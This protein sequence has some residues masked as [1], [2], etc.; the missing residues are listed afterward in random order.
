MS[1]FKPLTV[2]LIAKTTIT[3]PTDPVKLRSNYNVTTVADAIQVDIEQ[4]DMIFMDAFQD[5]AV[6]ISFE[7][8]S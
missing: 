6:D 2:E 4:A 7:V 1:E 8:L 3:I 5:G